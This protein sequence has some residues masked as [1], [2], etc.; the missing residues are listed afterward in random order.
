MPRDPR[1][2]LFD[3]VQAASRI[4]RFVGTSS[5]A[6]YAGNDLLRAGVERQFEI[7]GESLNKLRSFDADM[8][9]GIREHR[10]IVG[11]RNLLIH[12]YADVDNA[13]R[14]SVV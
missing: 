14:K 13:D 1:A 10:K 9:A 3:I 7:I 6:D 11:F 4:Q 2:Y 5:F 12:G 8:A